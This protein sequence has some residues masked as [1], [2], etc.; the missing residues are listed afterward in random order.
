MYKTCYECKDIRQTFKR[1]LRYYCGQIMDN[2]DEYFFITRSGMIP[3]RCP[4]LIKNKRKIE[5][6]MEYRVEIY[7]FVEKKWGIMKF[8]DFPND[9]KKKDAIFKT[10]E[11]AERLKGISHVMSGAYIKTRII[12]REK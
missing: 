10:K 1:R 12:R 4:I 9:G 6:E 3:R 8:W 7:N 5:A 11:Q 2:N